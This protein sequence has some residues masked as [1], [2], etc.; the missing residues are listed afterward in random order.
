MGYVF[1][2]RTIRRMELLVLSTLG[3]KMYPVT[4]LSLLHRLL[5]KLSVIACRRLDIFSI[6]E[7]ALLDV[8]SDCRWVQL[9]PSVWAAAAILHSAKSHGDPVDS[10]LPCPSYVNQSLDLLRVAKESAEDGCRVI[11]ELTGGDHCGGIGHKRRHLDY[12]FQNVLYY[13]PSRSSRVICSCFSC[14]SSSSSSDSLAHW[15]PSLKKP[16]LNPVHDNRQSKDLA[17][18]KEIL[19]A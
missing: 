17:P 19:L 7:V 3:W 1:E 6:C 14:Q 9:P 15:L 18:E 5:P 11:T 4:P 2:S 10:T 12:R 13:S 16:N 8:I